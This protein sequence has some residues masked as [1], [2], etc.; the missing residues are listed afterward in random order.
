MG[1]KC[2]QYLSLTFELL[3]VGVSEEGLFRLLPNNFCM[4]CFELPVFVMVYI[5]SVLYEC[6]AIYSTDYECIQKEKNLTKCK[7]KYLPKK[8]YKYVRFAHN[9]LEL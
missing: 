5:W 3:D 6:Y 1:N 2:Q 7:K 8:N 9:L 4:F